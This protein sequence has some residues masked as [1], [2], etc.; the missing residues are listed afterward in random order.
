MDKNAAFL[1]DTAEEVMVRKIPTAKSSETV[2]H[3][4]SLLAKESWDDIHSI[5]VTSEQDELLGVVP[6]HKLL[7][8]EKGEMLGRVMDKIKLKVGPH[9]DQEKIVVEAIRKDITSV[10]VVDQ[11]NRLIGAVTADQIVDILHEEHLEDLLRAS[12]IRGKGSHIL[13]LVDA[14]FHHLIFVR[15]PWLFVGLGVGLMASIVISGFESFLDRNVALAFFIS[16]IAYMSDA[17]GTQSETIFIRSITV[18]NF[19]KMSYILREFLVGIVL[20]GIMGIC[21][22]LAAF[23][24]SHSIDISFAVGISLLLSMSVS[25]VLACVT[26]LALKAMGRDPAIGSG[27]FTTALQDLISITIYFAVALLILGNAA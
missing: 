10:P 23:F 1:P 5:Y 24:I 14:R 9:T 18:M 26:P 2:S 27:P 15:L 7:I 21:A 17:I 13:E 3:M 12:G 4:L 11:E 16:M 8:S 25:T 22:G 19:N 20:G 6:I